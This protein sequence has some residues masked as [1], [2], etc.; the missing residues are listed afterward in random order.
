MVGGAVARVDGELPQHGEQR[1]AVHGGEVAAVQGAG[2]SGAVAGEL[3]PGIGE[4]ERHRTA[5]AG[6]WNAA[7]EA[8]S[9]Q[10]PKHLGGCVDVYAGAVRHLL[11]RRS[12]APVG[13]SVQQS[14]QDEEPV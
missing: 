11:L 10:S 1:L 7:H 8:A 14:R 9:L 12:R 5:V 13:L 6:V 3:K 4:T 2:F